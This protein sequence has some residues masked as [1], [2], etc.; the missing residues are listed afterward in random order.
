MEN[1]ALPKKVD[2]LAGKTENE[3]VVVVEPLY[4]GYGMTLGNSLRRVLLSSLPGAAVVGVK[5]KGASHEFMTLPGIQEDVL[6]IMLNIKQL[7]IKMYGD[8]EV[9]LELK[10]KG[11]Q[12]VTA[13]NI[14]KNS[15]VE[16]KNPELLIAS[17]TEEKASLE[18]EIFVRPGRG[19]RLSEGTKKENNE[20]GY[21]EID[22]IFSPVLAVSLDV[23]NTRVGKMT[24]WDKLLITLKTD[25]T[26]SP[27]E[28]FNQAVQI[29]VDQFS[30]LLPS[31]Q[32]PAPE[33]ESKEE[34]VDLETKEVA[35]VDADEADKPA[36]KKS[37][38]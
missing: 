17:L 19:Y 33:I 34:S 15:Q 32:K 5:I 16:I 36:K 13:A 2:F 20:L 38:K 27:R 24:N 23:E 22:S 6:E 25:G 29:L 10:V 4:P 21:M 7:H 35:E 18:A 11:K 26:I 30:A 9:R 8:E 3:G 28:A 31:A 1:I 12:L 14:T 37:K